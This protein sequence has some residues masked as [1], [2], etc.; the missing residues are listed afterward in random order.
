MNAGKCLNV[1]TLPSLEDYV[2]GV[3]SYHY[4]FPYILKENISE[5]TMPKQFYNDLIKNFTY[6]YVNHT[7]RVLRN[8]Q[9]QCYLPT[10]KENIEDWE[11]VYFTDKK[12]AFQKF[13]FWTRFKPEEMMECL[14]MDMAHFTDESYDENDD[15]YSIL[16]KYYINWES[17]AQFCKFC[18]LHLI[19]EKPTIYWFKLKK[20][21]RVQ[22][23][24]IIH[25]IQNN[26]NF[27]NC[28]KLGNL[29]I[30]KSIEF[31][32]QFEPSAYLSSNVKSTCV[33]YMNINHC[34]SN[35][36]VR[37]LNFKYCSNLQ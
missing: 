35:M 34:P 17:N 13:L 27:C 9:I 1:Q 18:F 25:E 4:K 26:R 7:H 19:K 37:E 15:W 21:E 16:Y 33:R 30:I 28:C 8:L 20:C 11:P 14:H 10:S 23:K 29:I 22:E 3:L 32:H 36:E 31:F 24:F 2:K 6:Y 5:N 12:K